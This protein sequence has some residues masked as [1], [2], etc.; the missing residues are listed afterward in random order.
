MRNRL[1]AIIMALLAS[2]FFLQACSSSPETVPFTI[3][4]VPEQLKG[5]SIAGQHV[6][7]LCSELTK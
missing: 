4:V 1:L 6:V 2:V 3:Q 5:N 7:F